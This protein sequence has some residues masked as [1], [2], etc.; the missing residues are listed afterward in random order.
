MSTQ[1]NILLA[2]VDVSGSMGG[3]CSQETLSSASQCLKFSGQGSSDLSSSLSFSSGSSRLGV[4]KKVLQ[5][6]VAHL[7]SNEQLHFA[8]LMKFDNSCS[9]VFPMSKLLNNSSNLSGFNGAVDSLRTEGGTALWNALVQALRNLVEFVNAQRGSSSKVT[10]FLTVLT[11]GEDNASSSSSQGR[12]QQLKEELSRICEFHAR[13]VAFDYDMSQEN[14]QALETSLGAEVQKS[15]DLKADGWF[16]QS[17]VTNHTD[18]QLFE[19]MREKLR[20]LGAQ[21]STLDDITKQMDKL[22]V[23]FK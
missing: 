6:N 12:V 16:D 5:A 1:V 14:K 3:S 11:D 19:K 22:S 13:I 9:V 18:Y 8:G 2:L 17:T 15:Q 20:S 7:I 23:S 21:S 10:A 4:A